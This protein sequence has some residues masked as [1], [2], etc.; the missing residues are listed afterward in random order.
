M[1]VERNYSNHSVYTEL[2]K[3]GAKRVNGDFRKY[4]LKKIRDG[5]SAND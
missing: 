2:C 5:D 3:T 1:V 4:N